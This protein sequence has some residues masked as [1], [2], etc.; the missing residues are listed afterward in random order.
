MENMHLKDTSQRTYSVGTLTYTK[1]ALAVLFL[2]LLAGDFVYIIIQQVEPRLLPV[3]LK[4]H[5][6]T[7]QQIAIIAGSIPALMN[8]C[9]N[10]V[11]GYRSDRK[12]SKWGRRIPYLIVATPFVSIFLAAIPFAPG[13]TRHA[14]SFRWLSGL[15]TLSP[16]APLML[17]FALLVIFYESAQMVITPIYIYLFRDVV[18]M[19][20]MGRFLA[21][22]R[23][24]SALGTF[25]INYWLVGLVETH[26]KAIFSGLAVLNLICFVLV[27]YF[28]REGEYPPVSDIV[29]ADCRVAR[30]PL[31][32]AAYNFTQESF[33]SR[34]YW[35]TYIARL[36]IYASIP[37]SGFLIFFAQREVGLSFDQAGKYLA[38][39]SLAWV[40]VAYPIGLLMDRWRAIRALTVALWV[41]AIAYTLSFFF[42]VGAK[43]FFVSCML[44]GMTYWMIMLGQIMLAQEVFSRERMGQLYAANTMIQSLVI[45]CITGPLTGWILSILQNEHYAW[46][47]PGVGMVELGP[48]R[49]INLLLAGVFSFSLFAVFRLRKAL[50][51]I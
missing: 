34:V 2:W 24:F 16:W 10:P 50:S 48:Y 43:T 18:P 6:A 28:V 11:V 13:L 29:P 37:M 33:T 17:I 44:T 39:P 15:F 21:L 38:W 5:G 4:Q 19:E 46:R 9:I 25:T 49:F 51:E 27:C 20:F 31:Y 8:F 42:V 32:R 23:V 45:A 22:M 30:N 7:D 14:E 12:R 26:A 1:A 47:M 41:S 35:W 3:L 40:V 36:L